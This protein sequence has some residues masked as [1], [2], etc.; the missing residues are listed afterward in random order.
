MVQVSFWTLNQSSWACYWASSCLST[1]L[2][3]SE[4]SVQWRTKQWIQKIVLSPT[5]QHWT[6]IAWFHFAHCDDSNWAVTI[7]LIWFLWDDF[8]ASNCTD[9]FEIFLFRMDGKLNVCLLS[10][11]DFVQTKKHMKHFFVHKCNL[12]LWSNVFKCS[13][14][15]QPRNIHLLYELGKITFHC[16]TLDFVFCF[17]NLYLPRF[18]F[19]R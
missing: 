15:S 11:V 14:M 4:L 10:L 1:T 7:F 12:L 9:F 8:F 13:Q 18:H 16:H 6:T 17:Q 3:L 2:F 5:P 19:L